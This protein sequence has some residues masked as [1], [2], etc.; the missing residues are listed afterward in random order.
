MYAI[1]F[2]LNEGKLKNS[3]QSFRLTPNK[4]GKWI[5]WNILFF[6]QNEAIFVQLDELD[7]LDKIIRAWIRIHL[8]FHTSIEYT[9]V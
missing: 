3:C 8:Q 2:S 1:G 9:L 7:K 5:E 4:C 6:F